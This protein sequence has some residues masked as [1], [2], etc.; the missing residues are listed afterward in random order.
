MYGKQVGLKSPKFRLDLSA[1]HR[2]R[3]QSLP[4]YPQPFNNSTNNLI[5]QV[6]T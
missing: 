5:Y 4:A 3:E 6:K 1:V 2:N